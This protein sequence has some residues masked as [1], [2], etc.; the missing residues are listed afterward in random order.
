MVYVTL[1]PWSCKDCRN[2][3]RD[4]STYGANMHCKV[5]SLFGACAGVPGYA[6]EREWLQ[7]SGKRRI[8]GD[9]ASEDSLGEGDSEINSLLS[10]FLSSAFCIMM[11]WEGIFVLCGSL[12]RQ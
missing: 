2:P 1:A 9:S 4:I 6:E 10:E 7:C 11:T 5:S 12:M 8:A 3:R